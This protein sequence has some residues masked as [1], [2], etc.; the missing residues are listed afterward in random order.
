MRSSGGSSSTT[1]ILPGAKGISY[2]SYIISIRKCRLGYSLRQSRK[3]VM[4]RR[5]GKSPEREP[6]D[7]AFPGWRHH[8][9]RIDFL[10]SERGVSER[11]SER[12]YGASGGPAGEA[13]DSL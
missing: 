8:E 7:A 3:R 12:H 6:P 1:R 4:M 11:N 9:A 2:I 13:G 10:V 5:T